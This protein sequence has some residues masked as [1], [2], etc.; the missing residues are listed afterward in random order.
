MAINA[1]NTG[2][3]PENY[4]VII[5]YYNASNK[6]LG[7]SEVKTTAA[8]GFE[9]GITVPITIAKPEGTTSASIMLWKS[10]TDNTPYSKAL[11][12]R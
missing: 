12:F 5:A 3:T 2:T 4:S 8:A 10:A 11:Y 9:G 6:L 1:V 7:V